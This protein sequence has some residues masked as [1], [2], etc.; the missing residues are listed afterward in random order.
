MLNE[1]LHFGKIKVEI[2]NQEMPIIMQSRN[3]LLFDK[4]QPWVKKLGNEEFDVPIRY[5]N[6]LEL[7]EIIGIYIF[8]KLRSVLQKDN[9]GLY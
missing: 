3:T 4:N 8:T 6:G 2:T 5:F 7:C 9:T 1:A